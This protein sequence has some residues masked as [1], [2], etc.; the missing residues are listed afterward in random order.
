MSSRDKN[1]SPQ[2]RVNRKEVRD[3]LAAEEKRRRELA[4]E[5]RANNANQP[6]YDSAGNPLSEVEKAAQRKSQDRAGDWQNPNFDRERGGWDLDQVVGEY[7]ASKGE[8]L[9]DSL[10]VGNW[11]PRQSE[12]DKKIQDRAA[13]GQ[14]GSDIA[15]RK[16]TPSQRVDLPNFGY[17]TA[18]NKWSNVM[19]IK[20][21]SEALEREN[22]GNPFDKAMDNYRRK[23]GGLTIRERIEALKDNKKLRDQVFNT[24]KITQKGLQVAKPIIKKKLTQAALVWA[25]SH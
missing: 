1:K 18:E 17:D 9:E 24:L 20:D 23:K 13:S 15:R 2:E 8:S 3:S 16:Q 6:G 5:L 11:N 14:Q 4:D 25:L 10:K 12:R 7:F 21:M 19:T 22:I